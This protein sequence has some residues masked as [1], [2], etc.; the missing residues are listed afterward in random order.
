ME[1]V[2]KDGVGVGREAVALIALRLHS[3]R[4][5]VHLLQ[6]G[7]DGRMLGRLSDHNTTHTHT[8]THTHTFV[9]AYAVEATP[10]LSSAQS[11]GATLR[12][13]LGR[14]RVGNPN[15]Y[16]SPIPNA[17]G[18]SPCGRHLHL[19]APPKAIEPS[20]GDWSARTSGLVRALRLGSNR[21][22]GCR[23]GQYRSSCHAH[24]PSHTPHTAHAQL[25]RAIPT[26]GRTGGWSERAGGWGRGAK[27][28]REVW[29][30]VV[31]RVRV[32][33]TDTLTDYIQRPYSS[34]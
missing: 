4:V 31:I 21:F 17:T 5:R 26:R 8:N 25:F 13:R 28:M 30:G 32:K 19:K 16:L 27:A 29:F 20:H 12:T 34:E 7:H 15:P 2:S 33:V 24:R 14:V 1:G 9:S 6:H 11:Q 10:V 3:R 22:S 18:W 23:L